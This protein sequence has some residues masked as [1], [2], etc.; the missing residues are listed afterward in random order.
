MQKKIPKTLIRNIRAQ[1]SQRSLGNRLHLKVG[2]QHIIAFNLCVLFSPSVVQP[3]LHQTAS[4]QT[5][6]GLCQ[7]KSQRSPAHHLPLNRQEAVS[8]WR[9]RDPRGHPLVSS[10]LPY[11]SPQ[12]A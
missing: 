5:L 6:P 2:P 8:I 12:P 10:P 7:E 3:T 9:G 1:V 11:H 4:R